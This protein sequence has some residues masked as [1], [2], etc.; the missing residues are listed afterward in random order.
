M[1]VIMGPDATA[2]SIFIFL[3]RSGMIVPPKDENVIAA[4]SDAPMQE[5]I[6]RLSVNGLS[7][8]RRM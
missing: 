6:E 7:F 8:R 4:R 2:G 1:V 5:A 3:N